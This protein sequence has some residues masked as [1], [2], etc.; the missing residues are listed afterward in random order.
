[1]NIYT[2]ASERLLVALLVSVKVKSGDKDNL[3]RLRSAACLGW[4]DFC[5]RELLLTCVTREAVSMDK[6]TRHV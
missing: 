4:F 2:A 5:F 3:E 1:M 6:L